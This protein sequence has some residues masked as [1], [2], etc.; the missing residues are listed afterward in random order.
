MQPYPGKQITPQKQ[1]ISLHASKK[2]FIIG[3]VILLILLSF[4]GSYFLGKQ[5]GPLSGSKA[6]SLVDLT[7]FSPDKVAV[8]NSSQERE[9]NFPS[10]ASQPHDV[11]FGPFRLKGSDYI[12]DQLNSYLAESATVSGNSNDANGIMGNAFSFQELLK[13]PI[14][15][16]SK[17][18]YSFTS[19]YMNNNKKT[20]LIKLVDAVSRYYVAYNKFPVSESGTYTWIKEMVERNEMSGVYEYVLETTSPVAYCGTVSQTGYCYKTDGQ[21][22]IIYVRLDQPVEED[23]CGDSGLFFLWTSKDNKLGELCMEDEP[24]QLGGFTFFSVRQ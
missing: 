14:K 23:I 7:K 12:N 5:T 3:A 11:Y 20:T 18:S 8:N 2:T 13:D 4:S 10:A 9:G 1:K 16:V 19:G 22:A 24:T 6:F 21:D 17:L 15:A